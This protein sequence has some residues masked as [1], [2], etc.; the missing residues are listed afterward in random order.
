MIRAHPFVHLF[1]SYAMI[2]L[3]IAFVPPNPIIRL[4]AFG[5]VVACA[6]SG[7]LYMDRSSASRITLE[8][9]ALCQCGV[10]LYSNYFLL[11]MK[12]TPP[13]GSSI[14]KRL[15][16]AVD[17]VLNPRGIGTS[18][19]IKNLPAFSK[20]NRN[21]VPSRPRFIIQRVATGLIFYALIEAFYLAQAKIYVPSL[22]DGDYSEH[23]ERIIRR[24]GEA[25]MH[26]L[27]VRAWLP[28]P[29]LFTVWCR[30]QY[31]H[32]LVSVIAVALGD[33]P[34][35]WPPLYGDVREAHSL[36]KFWGF[37]LIPFLLLFHIC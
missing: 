2:A 8:Y 19:Q 15:I 20:K 10:I 22:Q 4:G 33:E 3:S 6:I 34:R 23:K 36:R 17:L 32:S 27:L 21:Y 26:E 9:C 29:A 37:V 30:H 13:L 25:S 12:A 31:L 24:I 28:L 14:A 16:W 18:W 11:F 1:L 7:I 35:R 5:G